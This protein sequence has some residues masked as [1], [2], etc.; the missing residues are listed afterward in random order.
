ML[1]PGAKPITTDS[2]KEFRKALWHAKEI[3]VLP[4]FSGRIQ[5]I[6]YIANEDSLFSI[7]I[8]FQI[9]KA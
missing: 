2:L 9:I 8:H 4:P 1:I 7:C 6:R 5:V 3:Q